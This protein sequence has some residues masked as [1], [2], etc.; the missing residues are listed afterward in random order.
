VHPAPGA[1][2]DNILISQQFPVFKQM[3][4]PH[5]ELLNYS[6]KKENLLHY[7]RKYPLKS[8]PIHHPN[9]LNYHFPALPVISFIQF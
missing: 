4:E 2:V 7:V 1:M 6:N 3:Y 9:G 8:P 5:C